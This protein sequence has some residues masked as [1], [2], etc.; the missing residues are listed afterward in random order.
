MNKPLKSQNVKDLPIGYNI[1][2]SYPNRYARSIKRMVRSNSK[3]SKGY[4]IKTGYDEN[5]VKVPL[6][7]KNGKTWVPNPRITKTT[8]KYIH[9]N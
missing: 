3:S 4:I 5:G 6:R 2:G 7:I 9:S 8:E 1:T